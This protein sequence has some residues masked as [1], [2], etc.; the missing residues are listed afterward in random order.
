MRRPS[1]STCASQLTRIVFLVAALSSSQACTAR[2][3]PELATPESAE[4]VSASSAL[5]D[6]II[7]LAAAA[8][9]HVF[10]ESEVDAP[11]N[12]IFEN[13]G[14]KHPGT[15][16]SATVQ[17]EFVVDSTGRADLKTFQSLRPETDI[18]LRSIRRYLPSA[19]YKPARIGGRAVAQCVKQTFVFVSD[20]NRIRY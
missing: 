19:R 14:P 8:G 5:C 18:F 20:T 6:D 16:E 10:R 4:S 11:A 9:Q 12:P 3:A 1:L 7:R 13:R 2:Q 15:Q 17:T